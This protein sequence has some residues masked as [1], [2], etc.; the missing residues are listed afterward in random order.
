MDIAGPDFPVTA[1]A[2][3]EGR[4]LAM[5]P[6]WMLQMNVASEE[7][8]EICG[9]QRGLGGPASQRVWAYG[10]RTRNGSH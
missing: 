9:A 10:A 5:T 2:S 3:A 7:K 4:P 1:A 6:S 8:G